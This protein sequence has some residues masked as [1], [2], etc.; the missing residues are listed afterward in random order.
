MK[1]IPL[2]RALLSCFLIL[3][4][5]G[6]ALAQ[7]GRNLP[8]ITALHVP[9]PENDLGFKI[10]TD[11][12][13]AKWERVVAYFEH[14]DAASDRMMVENLGK[15]TLGRPFIVATISA[16]ENLKRLDELKLIQRR[17]AD[18]RGQDANLANELI[19]RGKTVVVITC[20]IHSTEVG[21]TFTATELAYRLT[22]SNTPEIRQILRIRSRG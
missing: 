10:G 20:S 5:P 4:L 12:K 8:N 21:G 6:F 18:P 13:L 1:L 9:A 7:A 16:P 19:Q 2:R 15:T 14:L 11:R 22:S 3:C 17:L